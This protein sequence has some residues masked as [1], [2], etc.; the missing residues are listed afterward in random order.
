MK[1]N[2]LPKNPINFTAKNVNKNSRERIRAG[3]Q[4][5]THSG[6]VVPTDWHQ[7]EM[8]LFAGPNYEPPMGRQGAPMIVPGKPFTE[9]DMGNPA[10]ALN[11]RTKG[12]RMPEQMIDSYGPNSDKMYGALQSTEAKRYNFPGGVDP[13]KKPLYVNWPPKVSP[14]PLKPTKGG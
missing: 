5:D 9:T 1:D 2:I 10:Q 14:N 3:S 12:E 11:W 13:V 4:I 8:N 7:N 6:N